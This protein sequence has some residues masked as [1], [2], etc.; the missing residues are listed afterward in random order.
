[1]EVIPVI[2]KDIAS[3]VDDWCSYQNKEH[4]QGDHEEVGS[5]NGVEQETDWY[6]HQSY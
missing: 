5:S 1:M 4:E 6:L 3:E 2:V